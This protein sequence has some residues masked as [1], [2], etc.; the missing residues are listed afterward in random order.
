MRH[1][2]SIGSTPFVLEIAEERFV[3][4]Q[5][6]SAPNLADPLSRIAEAL[7]Q[8]F[9]YPALR[10]ALTPDDQV[11]VVVDESLPHVG[12][13]LGP[14]LDH[15]TAAG[16]EP[17]AI[18]LLCPASR[19]D[20]A[21]RQE[22]P[23]IHR[24]TTI[25][26]H[27]PADTRGL[28]YLA[29]T[30][31]GQR[32]YL[33]RTLVEADHIVVLSG[34]RYDPTLGYAGGEALLYPAFADAETLENQVVKV[35]SLPF[36]GTPEILKIAREITWLLGAPFFIQVIEGAGEGVAAV[37]TGAPTSLEEGIR[38]QDDRWRVKV[39]RSAD[40]I[41]ATLPGRTTFEDLATAASRAARVVRTNGAVV[42]LVDSALQP[43][44]V[45]DFLR[46]CDD[47]EEAMRKLGRQPARELL[48]AWL[49]AGAAVQARLYLH[50]PMDADEV[51]RLF[52]TPL[53][54][55]AQVQRLAD[56]A[57]Q[58]MLLPDAHKTLPILDAN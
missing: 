14:V 20:Q 27:D 11:V 35:R 4:V 9:E 6:S 47:P 30:E 57:T 25:Q 8:P 29:T 23:A 51:E 53:D 46:K 1:T 36:K 42:L 39:P 49:W 21:W 19:S 43:G 31:E 48:S 17:Q 52:A 12:R 38:R 44:A 15:L 41:I 3:P 16:V 10:Q 28:C 56:R 50:S 18:T 58:V 26:V 54:D 40:L 13:L 37:V 33:N 22:L 55:L 45:G 32:V 34:R 7:E 5:Q 2:V 24:R